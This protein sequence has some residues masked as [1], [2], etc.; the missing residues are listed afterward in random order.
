MNCPKCK[1]PYGKDSRIPLLL[2][3]CGHSVCQSCATSLFKSQSICCPECQTISSADSVSKF[4]KNMALLTVSQTQISKSQN[5]GQSKGKPSKEEKQKEPQC[6]MHQ[7]K[8]EAFCEDDKCLLCI[9]CILID[10]HKSHDIAPIPQA[11]AKEKSKLQS[12]MEISTKL[13]EKLKLLLGDISNYR[14]QLTQKANKNREKITSIYREITNLIQERE[15]SLKLNIANM[16][17]KEEA[18]LESKIKIIEEQLQNIIIFK[19]EVEGSQNEDDCAILRNS[20]QRLAKLMEANK[21]IPNISFSLTFPEIKRDNEIILLCKQLNQAA[22]KTISLTN[23]YSATASS[24]NKKTDRLHKGVPTQVKNTKTT[25]KP[26]SSS[27]EQEK[28]F[29]PS[30]EIKVR[31]SVEK[32]LNTIPKEKTISSNAVMPEMHPSPFEEE[33]II[34]PQVVQASEIPKE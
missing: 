18:F 13:E 23:I 32:E 15:G 10:G 12:D 4:P 34:N 9:N 31:T 28:M 25:N 6:E 2:I 16:L 29:S 27:S 33:S 7:K 3:K 24:T 8:I 19:G 17:E 20:K 1:T 26:L 21:A 11:S 22:G 14:E 30:K 5:A